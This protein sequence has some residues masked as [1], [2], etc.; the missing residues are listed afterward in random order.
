LDNLAA[1]VS[2]QIH[3]D[4]LPNNASVALRVEA[5][6]A[7][8]FEMNRFRLNETQ[9][10]NDEDAAHESGNTAG[11]AEDSRQHELALFADNRSKEF[12]WGWQPL[13]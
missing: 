2:A 7:R 8:S 10:Q 3:L 6:K 9:E 13:G 5:A 4:R 11:K 1:D 12:T